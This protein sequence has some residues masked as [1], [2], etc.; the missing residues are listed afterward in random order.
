MIQ[1][2]QRMLLALTHERLTFYAEGA[3]AYWGMWGP[4]GQPAIEAVEMWERTQRRY[5]RLWETI[6]APTSS[7]Q[8]TIRGV[9]RGLPVDFFSGFGLLDFDD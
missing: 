8:R 4:M 5:L 2:T 3:K 6:L 1:A 7:G 9:G